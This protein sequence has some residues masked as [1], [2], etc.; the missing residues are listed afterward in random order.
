MQCEQYKSS[1]EEQTVQFLFVG[2]FVQFFLMLCTIYANLSSS[3]FH[4]GWFL[5]IVANA[6]LQPWAS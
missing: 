2:L 6:S 3:H 4:N 1:E 5:Q